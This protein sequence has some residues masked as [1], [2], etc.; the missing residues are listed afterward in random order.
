MGLDNANT[1]STSPNTNPVIFNFSDVVINQH[2]TNLLSRGFKFAPTQSTCNTTDFSADTINFTYKVTRKLNNIS[3]NSHNYNTDLLKSTAKKAPGKS[4]NTQIAHVLDTIAA[5]KPKTHERIN[6]NIPK[7]EFKIIN[8]LRDNDNI[9]IKEADKGA[10][11]VIMNVSDYNNT[12]QNMLEDTT[13]YEKANQNV[14]LNHTVKLVTKFCKAWSSNITKQETDV[15]TKSPSNTTTIY[16]LPKIHKSTELLKNLENPLYRPN[17]YVYAGPYPRDMKF[18]PIISCC[19]CP[20]KQLCILLDNILRPFLPFVKFRIQDTWEFLRKCPNQVESDTYAITAD[21]TSLYTNIT[22]ESGINAI[23]FYFDNFRS[24]TALPQRITKT[25]VI[26]LY[27]FCQGHLFFQF[28]GTMFRQTSGT[29]MGK[30]FAPALADL[31]IGFDEIKLE[32]YVRQSFDLQVS[33]FFLSHYRRYLDDV[34]FLWRKKFNNLDKIKTFMNTIDSKIKYTFESS[35]E[36]HNS[37]PFLDVLITI[38]NGNI[39]TDIYSKPTDTYNYVPFNSNHPRHSIRNIPFNLARR[40]KGI[41]SDPNKLQGRFQDMA[42]RLK[43][44][45]YPT[46]LI[47]GAI[48]RAM[49]LNRD[50]IIKT[51]VKINSD[52]VNENKVFFIHTHNNA[53]INPSIQIKDLITTINQL[54]PTSA[55]KFTLLNA[56]RRSPNLRNLLMFSQK[57]T[58]LVKRCY[59]GCVFCSY[60]HE[61]PSLTLKT[62]VILKPNAN[63][64]CCSRNLVY[65]IVGN[66]CKEFYIGETGDMIKNRFAVHRS[67]GKPDAQFVPV[68]ADQ[69][70]RTCDRDNYVVFPFFRPPRDDFVLRKQ[71]EVKFIRSLKPKLNS[72]Q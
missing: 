28:E 60:L 65:I 64:T 44:K 57:K 32:D 24:R 5:I 15:I 3:I 14:D 68:K 20:T 66:R 23:N 11:V 71:Y 30:D 36:N 62:G 58:Y 17:S 4:E 7:D 29:G 51:K 37:I 56:T 21:I 1:I 43:T 48:N 19:L 27:K 63:F 10:A 34:I 69:H 2:E 26:E 33:K 13:T 59:K 49:S 40:I 25:F 50:D 31:K 72:L 6:H 39:D 22:T 55:K 70:L 41:V 16:G 47:K 46:K 53:I 18:R 42:D 61:G 52:N 9:V 8:K 67:Q 54:L 45:K 12:L 35:L 38:E